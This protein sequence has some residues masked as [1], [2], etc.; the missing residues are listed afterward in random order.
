MDRK[1]YEIRVEGTFDSEWA[2]WF[3]D[4]ELREEGGDTILVLLDVDN[5]AFYGAMAILGTLDSGL[6]YVR[7]YDPCRR[8][9]HEEI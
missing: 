6:V 1:S 3:G 9:N 2:D 8:R 7:V 5:S 4:R